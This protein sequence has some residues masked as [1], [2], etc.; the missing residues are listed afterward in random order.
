MI[1]CLSSMLSWSIP[2]GYRDD[3][4]CE[5]VR[6]LK[7]GEPWKAWPWESINELQATAIPEMWWAGAIALYTGQRQG[8]VLQMSWSDIDRNTMAVVQEKTHT[9]VWVPIHRDQKAILAQI[10]RRSV[11]ILT[12]TNG[13]PW[14]KD[15]FKSSW[16]NQMKRLGKTTES[17]ADLVFHGLRKSS[18]VF[19][20]EAGCSTAEVR[21]VT[22]QSLQMVELYALDVNKRKLAASAILKWE[23]E[24]AREN[25]P[26]AEFVQPPAKLVQRVDRKDD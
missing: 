14:T 21:S 3:N 20:L 24:G 17:F 10:P 18:V 25:G 5:H 6:R 15:G 12:N 8:N 19:L 22:G 16:A 26:A 4:P 11:R 7:G 2:R 1:A 23:R 9:K 13:V